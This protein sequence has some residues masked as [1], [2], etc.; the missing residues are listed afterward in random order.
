MLL[1]RCK[2]PWALGYGAIEMLFIIIIIIIIIIVIIIINKRQTGWRNS[3]L[4]L[5]N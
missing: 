1:S 4:K 3:R 5:N 2:A